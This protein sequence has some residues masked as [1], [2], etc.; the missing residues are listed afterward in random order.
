MS[1]QNSSSSSFSKSWI[2][3]AFLA[4]LSSS[5]IYNSSSTRAYFLESFLIQN[6]ISSAVCFPFPLSCDTFAA[7][8]DFKFII[9]YLKLNYCKMFFSK[10]KKMKKKMKI[11]TIS[12][13]YSTT[14]SSN[15]F[16]AS[17]AGCSTSPYPYIICLTTIKQQV[18]IIIVPLIKNNLFDRLID[19][20]YFTIKVITYKTQK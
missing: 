16:T 11:D 8:F 4:F 13:I 6:I 20:L 18:K 7:F 19:L 12:V 14:I 2:S 9:Y 15:T 5:C 1:F 3:N 17:S 10:K